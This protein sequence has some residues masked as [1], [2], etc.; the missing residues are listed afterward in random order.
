MTTHEQYVYNCYLET[1]RKLN[2]KPFRYRK[3][4]DN[5]EEKE[6]Y[7]YV[8]KLA[9]FFYKF[10]NIN[11]KDFFEAP[12]FVY[13]ESQFDLKFFVG[14]K[15]IK[16]YTIYQN[17]FL[18]NNPDHDQTIQKIKD[19]FSFIYNFCKQ[20]QINFDSYCQYVDP[21]RKWH[22]FFIHLKDRNICLYP[23]FSFPSFDKIVQQYDREIKEYV[24]GD[25]FQN[26]NYFRTKYYSSS[27]AKKFCIVA[28]KTL[29]DKLTSVEQ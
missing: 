29:N 23:L 19:S 8:A 28:Y 22:E 27:K 4:F 17:K 15:A 16:A 10:P 5:F 2:N 26:I 9:S 25:T 20:K 24:F 18:V 3:N 7:S 12:Y 6:E 11:I 14:Q 13:N 1:S 21:T